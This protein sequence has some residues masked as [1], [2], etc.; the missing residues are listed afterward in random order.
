[1]FEVVFKNKIYEFK[2]SHFYNKETKNHVT[3]CTMICLNGTISATDQAVCGKKDVYN[4]LI[5]R[6]KAL[7]RVLDLC[8]DI[9]TNKEER[10]LVWKEFLWENDEFT[11]YQVL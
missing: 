8:K 2:F 7:C 10:K 3:K 5:G 1:M 11:A 6:K 4:K 9:F